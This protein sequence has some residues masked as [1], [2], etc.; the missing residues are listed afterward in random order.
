MLREGYVGRTSMGVDIRHG[1]ADCANEMIGRVRPGCQA[2]I[3]VAGVNDP[4]TG[5]WSIVLCGG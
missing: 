3:G 5:Q 4:G 1:M 2:L